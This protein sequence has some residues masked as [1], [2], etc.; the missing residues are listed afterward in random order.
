MPRLAQRHPTCRR[1]RAVAL[2]AGLAPVLIRRRRST[3]RL[4]AEE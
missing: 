4:L 3:A 1:V 2:L